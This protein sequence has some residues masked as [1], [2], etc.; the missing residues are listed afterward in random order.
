MSEL[1]SGHQFCL[2]IA[3]YTTIGRWRP[4]HSRIAYCFHLAAVAVGGPIVGTMTNEG[5]GILT[6][7]SNQ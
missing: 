2:T 1:M 7:E 6:Y 5:C 3:D 4:N